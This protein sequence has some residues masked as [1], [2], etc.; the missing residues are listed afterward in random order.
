MKIVLALG[1]NALLSDSKDMSSEAQLKKSK[2]SAKIIVDLIEAGH[3]ISIVHGNGPQI[4]Q[5]LNSIEIAHKM[6]R[7]NILFPFDVVG[8]F[9]QGYIGYYLQN[10]ISEELKNRKIDKSVGTIVTQI[11]VDKE[12]EAF[13]NPLKPIGV[14]Y[15]KEEAEVLTKEKG[16][17]MKEDS[18]RGYRRVVPSPKPLDIVEKGLIKSLV[19]TGNVVISCGGGGIPVIL[20]NGMIKGIPAVIDKDLAAEKLAEVLEADMLL[21][22]TGVDKISINFN[23]PNE[24][25][26]DCVNVEELNRYIEE[27]HFAPGSMLPKILACKEFVSGGLNRVSIITSL[28]KAKEALIGNSGTKIVF[29]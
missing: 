7:A 11:I 20:E 14:F 25:K 13:K 4:G 17:T 9:S 29:K 22:L 24:R 3:T 23:K 27:G 6:D 1:G 15:S 21:I 26:L 28:S 19:A 10:A 16:Y 12:D 5:I 8:A 2:E 18:G